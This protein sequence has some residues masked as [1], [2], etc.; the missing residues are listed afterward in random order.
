M[1]ERAESDAHYVYIV[2]CANGSLYTGYTKNIEARIA[3]HNG[4]KG[5]R[6]TKAHRPVELLASWKF[7]TKRQ[8]LQIEYCI[9]QLPRQ[10]K[11][12]LVQQ[13]D[14]PKWL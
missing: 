1:V 14:I 2:R 10:K 3:A 7:Q 12:K 6:Y 9:K 4:G 8:A 13:L 5:G 11:L